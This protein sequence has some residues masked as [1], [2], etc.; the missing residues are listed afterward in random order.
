MFLVKV[1]FLSHCRKKATR[2]GEQESKV[3]IFLKQ[4]YA[5]RGRVGRQVRGCPGFFRPAPPSRG[6]EGFC[7]YLDLIRGVMASVHRGD[8]LSARLVSSQWERNEQRVTSGCWRFPPFP[9]F[10][11]VSPGHLSSQNVWFPV[12]LEVPAFLC[13]PKDPRC[14]QD[15]WFPAIWRLPP[16]F[17]AHI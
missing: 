12:S 4:E 8:F 9:T 2:Q 16:P 14:L 6:E 7:P 13:L 17:S 10:L 15:A 11:C 5:V 3:R 1:R